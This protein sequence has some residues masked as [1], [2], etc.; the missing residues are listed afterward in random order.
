MHGEGQTATYCSAMSQPPEPMPSLSS[1]ATAGPPPQAVRGFQ[2][3]GSP[4]LM[5]QVASMQ[6]PPPPVSPL[7]DALRGVRGAVVAPDPGQSSDGAAAVRGSRRTGAVGHGH[8]KDRGGGG[9]GQARGGKGR[10]SGSV[11]G[12]SWR[13][14]GGTKRS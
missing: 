14:G 1:A 10:A 13:E 8:G 7:T 9:R 4:G 6:A 11:G 5:V 3:P 2:V 12:A